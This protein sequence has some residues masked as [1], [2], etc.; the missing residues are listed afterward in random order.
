MRRVRH[1]AALSAACLLTA[2]GAG[3]ATAAERSTHENAAREAPGSVT[4]VSVTPGTGRAEVVI[5]VEGTIEVFDFTLESPRRIVVDLRGA[6]LGVAAR[7]YDKVARGGIT[8]IRLAQ[9]KPGVVRV[10][11]DLDGEREYTVVRGEKDVRIS[12]AGPDRFTPW[13]IGGGTT[14]ATARN[15]NAAARPEPAAAEERVVPAPMTAPAPARRPLNARSPEEPTQQSQERRITVTF[16][17]THIRDVITSFAQFSGRTIVVGR[18][19]EGFVTADIKD[20]PWDLALKSILSSQQL[21]LVVE[22]SGIITVDS[23]T[24]IADKQRVEPVQTQVIQVNYAKAE[25]MA[26][27][28]RQLLGAG[29]GGGGAK[30]DPT[31]PAMP[32]AANPAG[33]AGQ[34]AAAA[35]SAANRGGAASAGGGLS[36]TCNSRGVV[37]FDEK[38]NS[39]IVTETP[40]RLTDIANYIRDLDVRTPQVAIKAKIIAVDRTG[41][42]QLGISYDLGSANTFSNAVLP[43]LNGDTPIPGDFRVNISGDGLAG[44]ANASR[45]YKGTS[46]LS[47]IY[48]MTLGGFNLTSFLDALSEQ[49]LSDVQAE[50]STTTVDNREAELFAGTQIAYLLTPPTVAGQLTASGPQQQKQDVG[51]T[52]RVTP[53]VTANHQVLMTV[54]AEQQSLAGATVAG[55]T[56]NKRFSRNE[57]LVG[58]GETAV[59]GGLTQTQVSRN[60]KGI[61]FLMSL[62]GIGRLFSETDTVERKQDL[63]ILITPRIIDDGEIVRQVKT[64]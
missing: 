45:S 30:G 35:Q 38:T 32:A 26:G 51:I 6:T 17:E 16:Q 34:Q 36:A 28:V 29:C 15:E 25:T 42:E 3:S 64:P 23:Y 33:N 10:V 21:A 9:Y 18:A 31:D 47:L 58:D 7:M 53:H 48:N 24:N 43:R 19:V 49:Q 37:S 59:I 13:T 52:L 57:V 22:P 40:G 54:Y 27:T 8:N 1:I 50:P 11:L 41:T 12:V 61:P 14:M 2:I 20:Q 63:L 56:I 39:V 44:V 55:P 60:K 5:A 4:A 46:S 62:P